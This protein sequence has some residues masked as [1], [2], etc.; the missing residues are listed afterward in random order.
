MDIFS[1]WEEWLR[2]DS[3]EF[4]PTLD[5]ATMIACERQWC[6]FLNAEMDWFFN[7]ADGD[8]VAYVVHGKKILGL[9]R[10]FWF[11]QPARSSSLYWKSTAVY[12]DGVMASYEKLVHAKKRWDVATSWSRP[13]IFIP[14]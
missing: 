7:H 4:T 5:T 3:A 6:H 11:S 13:E 12:W 2:A 10:W 8:D 9:L 14:K 1:I